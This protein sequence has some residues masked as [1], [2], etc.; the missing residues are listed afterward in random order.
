MA[1]VAKRQVGLFVLGPLLLEID[2]DPVEVPGAR[3]QTVLALLAMAAPHAVSTGRLLDAG[4]PDESPASGLAA[5]QSH[6][7][8][9]RRHLGAYR[10]RL[11]H[12]G[13]GYRL[14][15]R[16]GELDTE[17]FDRGYQE[18]RA[19][20]ATDP[21]TAA[22]LL[23]RTRSLWRGPALAGL[24]ENADLAAWARALTE[25]W[26]AASELLAECALGMGDPTVAG[27]VASDIAGADPL[28]ESA[29]T[30]LVRALA[31]QG[32]TA[33][34]LR[35]AYEFRRR[36]A[37]DT[38]LDP[39]PA[40]GELEQ[41]VAAGTEG[42]QRP[43]T[44]RQARSAHDGPVATPGVPLLGREAE[45]V[46]VERL[47]ASE[48]L[49]TIVGPGGVG[50]TH[51]AMELAR[52]AA[53]AMPAVVLR[54]D[55]IT[56]G[57]AIGDVLARRLGLHADAGDL[58]SRCAARLA[59]E[60]HLLVLDN[61]EHLLGAV[62]DMAGRLLESCPSLTI[63]ATSRERLAMPAEQ[64]CRLA[65]LPM[66]DPE[67]A[68]DAIGVPSVALFVDRA[69]RA[70]PDF[71]LGPRELP[72]VIA[73]VRAVD[74]L[75]LAIELAAGRLG[76]MAVG[77]VAARLDRALDLFGR[78][79]PAEVGS[80]RRHR[81]LR[82]AIE[83]SY[84]LLPDDERRLFRHL[85]VFPDGVDLDLAEVVAGELGQ[86]VDPATAMAHLADASMVVADLG[87]GSTRFRMLDSLR[88]FGLD[89][90]RADGELKGARE[91]LRRWALGFA[92]WF[93]VEVET[94]HEIAAAAALGR[95][96]A[97]LR[98]AWTDAR[99][100]GD[101]DTAAE[102]ALGLYGAASWRNLAEVWR[103][104]IEMAVDANV[105]GHR[106]EAAVLGLAAEACWYSAGDLDRAEELARRA[107][108]LSDRDDRLGWKVS[109]GALA[110]V[111]LFRGDFDAC[112]E[113]VLAGRVGTAWES[114]AYAHAAL[115]AGY[116]GD[117]DAADEL[118]AMAETKPVS[119]SVRAWIRYVE[120]EVAAGKG[121]WPDAEA[122]YREAISASTTTGAE[123]ITGI[124]SVGLVTTLA[125]RGAIG[126]ALDGYAGLIDYWERAG[127]WTQ[128]WTTLRN[129]ADLLDRLHDSE[130]AS[131]LRAAADAAP[132]SS[133]A[134][135]SAM[136][137]AEPAAPV[138]SR[139][140]ALSLARAAIE[141]A[142]MGR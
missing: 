82:S 3:R 73:I 22:A 15:L 115:A 39:T 101:I 16:P 31:A 26:F 116:A 50:K 10:D 60:A 88:Q 35:V 126:E 140:E 100:D 93:E 55:S 128:Q 12:T 61:C 131:R 78:G 51:L 47:L 130:T 17:M 121:A 38:G 118:L 134:A 125:G 104:A 42:R 110:N 106:L 132:E 94:D 124:A 70:A 127:G 62:R 91:R 139:D 74:G 53:E 117:L 40:L 58:L 5:L 57:E 87:D 135:P 107:C 80:D 77:D 14:D 21:A 46:G 69:R 27:A 45:L 112:R 41:A 109:R 71:E 66:P 120:G 23:E 113:L 133:A 6:V 33:E 59:T 24:D 137:G 29:V 142:R 76:A 11:T 92:R 67:R 119:P 4:W 48:R 111:M 86:S 30:L 49:V 141:R 63:L 9:I 20:A 123:F 34:A 37:A 95:E 18:A 56:A 54:L 136:A 84:R 1:T 43:A 44:V 64:T 89:R 129:L 96:F 75:P 102:I 138:A 8:R 108:E 36:L 32:R 13:S 81:T 114:E 79:T 98:A 83:W 25:R 105:R 103:W 99:G 97:N 68:A 28:R 85:A 19:L 90:L 7:S 72:A 52:R 122:A 2:G 65:P